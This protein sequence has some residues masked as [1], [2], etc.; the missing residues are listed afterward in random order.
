[1]LE[2]DRLNL[3]QWTENDLGPFRAMG[4]DAEVMKYFPSTFDR[5]A[6]DAMAK[7]C[8]AL[9]EERGWGFWAAEKV[10]TG[11]FIGFIGL[12]VPAA[13]LPCSPCVEVGWR[14]AREHWG[15][16]FATEGARACIDFAFTEL[17]LSEVVA[18]TSVHNLRSRAVMERI[19]MT[20]DSS[21]FIHPALPAN[22]WL[23]KHCLYRAQSR[24][25]LSNI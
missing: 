17:A 19:G 3:R 15:H 21:T 14:L 23:G 5:H 10:S 2:T 9:I 11:E 6:S 22:H 4:A 18:F 13:A 24:T 16:G 12:H 25:W 8:Q 1:M 20:Q 7:R